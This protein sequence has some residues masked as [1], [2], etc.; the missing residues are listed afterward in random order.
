MYKGKQFLVLSL[1]T[2]LKITLHYITLDIA[3]RKLI[4]PNLRIFH[5][6]KKRNSSTASVSKGHSTDPCG[7]QSCSPMGNEDE[8]FGSDV[9]V[10]QGGSTHLTFFAPTPLYV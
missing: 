5:Q 6:I 9:T 1:E 10:S 2:K 4:F 3:I 7:S 8:V